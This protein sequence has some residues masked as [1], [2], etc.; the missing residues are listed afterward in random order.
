MLSVQTKFNRYIL[1]LCE[2]IVMLGSYNSGNSERVGRSSYYLCVVII[3]ARRETFDHYTLC[4]GDEGKCCK[5][6]SIF[7]LSFRVH[8][9]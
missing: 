9:I 3:K 5:T 7:F 6:I 8:V 4:G 2:F 1:E